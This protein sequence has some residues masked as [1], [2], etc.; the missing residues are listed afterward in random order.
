M[1][2]QQS[3][4]VTI[5]CCCGGEPPTKSP[6]RRGW[7]IVGGV[8]SIAVWVFMPK[9]PICLAA[10]LALWTGLGLSFV[11]ATYLRQSLLLLSAAFLLYIFVKRA[12][13][14]WLR[15]ERTDVATDLTDDVCH[16]S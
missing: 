14:L 15:R 9:C 13:V 16:R 2:P 1:L 3:R 6:P 10:Y 12:C 7:Q 5:S 11:E 4:S 8:L